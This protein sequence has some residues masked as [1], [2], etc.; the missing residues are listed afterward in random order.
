MDWGMKNRL[1]KI[2]NPKTGHTVMLA[3]DHGY[4]Q[5]AISGLVKPRETI[6]PLL[7]YADAVMLTRGMLRN[8]MDPGMGTPV[9]LRV[10]GGNSILKEDLSDEEIT[11]SVREAV[12]L[13]ASAVAMSIYVGAPHEKQ[14][15]VNLARLVDECEEYGMPVLA[16]TAVGREMAR[17]AKYLSLATRIAA[18]LGAHFVKTYYCEGFERVVDGSMVPVVI[19]GGKKTDEAEALRIVHS[20]I[21]AGAVGVDFG[22]NIFQ[23]E[24]SVAMIRSIRSIVQEG[25]TADEALELF[26]SLKSGEG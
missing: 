12:R 10:S 15:L 24:Y 23:S 4:F 11:T 9:V 2:I 1:S 22:R 3:V 8:A 14:T 18:E 20:A 6:W 19:A 7:P 21:E 13:N 16:V 25:Y 5:G 26:N 17:D